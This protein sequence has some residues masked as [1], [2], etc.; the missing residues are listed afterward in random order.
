LEPARSPCGEHSSYSE[1]IKPLNSEL[2]LNR[3]QNF[4]FFSL[5]KS[6]VL[7]RSKMDVL[8]KMTI[9][10][11]PEL[12][13]D[14][15]PPRVH[16]FLSSS[17]HGRRSWADVPRRPFSVRKPSFI[18]SAQLSSLV[19]ELSP[20]GRDKNPAAVTHLAHEMA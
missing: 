9:R 11:K 8:S 14:A 20:A 13:I 12:G 4:L 10:E 17:T 6:S 2:P 15:S 1:Q 5:L 7:L 3:L 16:L 18:F 19:L